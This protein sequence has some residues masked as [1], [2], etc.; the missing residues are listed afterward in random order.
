MA[1]AVTLNVP[2][3]SAQYIGKV[4]VKGRSYVGAV[5]RILG[6]MFYSDDTGT[7]RFTN[8]YEVL[9]CGK[10]AGTTTLAPPPV[11]REFFLAF[12]NIQFKIKI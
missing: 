5:V 6:G 10:H 9:V 8:E 7:E 4:H 12:F 1:N 3:S 11:C 2:K